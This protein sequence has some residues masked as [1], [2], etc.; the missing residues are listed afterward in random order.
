[1]YAGLVLFLIPTL[2]YLVFFLF[3][4]YL[5]VKRLFSK[6]SRTYYVQI[7]WEVT[8]TFLVIG[9]VML[10]IFYSRSLNVLA[11]YI[12]IYA[13]MAGL[14]LLIRGI[15]YSYIFYVHKKT[16]INILDYLFSLMHILAAFF[17][18]ILIVRV[19]DFVNKYHPVAN[20]Q[21][22]PYFIP[23]LVLTTALIIVPLLMIYKIKD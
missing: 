4:T 17:L 8:H 1:M 7:T 2:I 10:F 23:G 18:V 14:F 21:F 19:I 13:F 5:S 6:D 20:T 16:N 22:I 9:L 15:L 3:E 11:G 12:F